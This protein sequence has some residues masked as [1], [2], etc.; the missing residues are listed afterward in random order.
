MRFAQ[1]V[2]D[3]VGDDDGIVVDLTFARHSR[4]LSRAMT[5]LF[6]AGICQKGLDYY[7]NT[8]SQLFEDLEQW[9]VSIPEGLHGL[10]MA[11][12][13]SVKKTFSRRIMERVEH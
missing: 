4:L 5:T 12:S 3:I 11:P 13:S 9:R 7:T 10:P 2:V 1:A 8:I 6:C